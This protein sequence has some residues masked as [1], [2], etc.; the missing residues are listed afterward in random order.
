MRSHRPPA[1]PIFRRGLVTFLAAGVCIALLLGTIALPGAAA[2]RVLKAANFLGE[3]VS[4]K[5]RQVADRVVSSNNNRS[6]PFI[7]IDKVNAEVFLFDDHGQLRGATPALLGLARGDDSVAGI[8]NRKMSTIRPGERT[9]P[10][11]RFVASMG[12]DNVGHT[13]LWVDYADSIALHRVVTTNPKEHRLERL[14]S[15]LSSERRISYGCINV[16]VKF[17]EKIVMPAFTGTNGI[18]YIIPETRSVG[19]SL[20]GG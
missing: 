20:Y 13:I 10:A 6:L 15:G 11:G 17:F 2:A 14:A 5:A 8:G 9:T 3:P 7:I 12:H 18:V 16:P 19:E 4:D 1:N